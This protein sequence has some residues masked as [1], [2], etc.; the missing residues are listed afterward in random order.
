MK[1]QKKQRAILLLEDGT[2]FHGKAAGAIG[3]A[4]GELCFNTGMTGYQEILTDPSYCGQ[5]ITK[6]YPHIGNYGINNEDIGWM[7]GGYIDINVKSTDIKNNLLSQ[8]DQPV[9]WYQIITNMRKAGYDNFIEVG[10]K[11][12]LTKL[13]KQI[14]PKANTLSSET[15]SKFLN[16]N[17]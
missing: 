4:T 10:P 13:N 2:I 8:I 5:L 9:L 11:Q 16:I 3:T 12:V 14:I 15:L 1:Y 6:T 7:S 17:V